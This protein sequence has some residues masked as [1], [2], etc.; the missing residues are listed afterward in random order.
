[1]RVHHIS[2]GSMCPYGGRLFDGHTRGFGPAHIACH[3]L[4]I[5]TDASGL[6]LVD[7]GIGLGDLAS[8]RKRLGFWRTVDRIRLDPADTA[9]ARVQA[10]GYQVQDVRHIVLT[11]LDFDHAGGITD[12]PAAVVHV[13]APEAEVA[14]ARTGFINRYRYRPAQMPAAMQEYR[15]G[16]ERWFGFEAVRNLRGLPPELLLVPLPGHTRGHCG[17]AVGG[18][19]PYWLLHAGDAYFHQSEIFDGEQPPPLARAYQVLMEMDREQR[20]ANQDR[21]RRLARD[22][23]DEIDI[24]CSHDPGEL[25][26][27]GAAV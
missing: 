17:V 13:H 23:P 27:Y 7:T 4:L 6:V 5:E 20:L 3:C 18:A 11:H 24:T 2:C 22:R 26:R 14:R 25:A 19:G 21:L 1:M 8:P 10:L 9:V 15:A 16:G 12:F